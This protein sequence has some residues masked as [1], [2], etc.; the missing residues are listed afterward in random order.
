MRGLL[1]PLVRPDQIHRDPQHGGSAVFLRRQYRQRRDAFI[2]A[3]AGR[4]PD[5]QVMGSAGGLHLTE[6]LP[7]EMHEGRL[8][9]AAIGLGLSVLGLA[10]MS[11]GT[12]TEPGIVISD[13]RATSSMS[14]EAVDRLVKAS[15][16]LD[17][18]TPEMEAV[19]ASSANLWHDLVESR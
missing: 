10:P 11:G 4:L 17:Q 9:A 1:V 16:V 13:A 14:E 5:W 3:L 12:R 15:R 7:P 2:E 18:V 19:A 8:V 6:A